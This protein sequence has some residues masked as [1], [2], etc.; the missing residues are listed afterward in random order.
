M[1]VLS[2][3]WE[4][5][6]LGKAVFLLRWGPCWPHELFFLGIYCWS[7]SYVTSQDKKWYYAA[8]QY[9]IV[10]LISIFYFLLTIAISMPWWD[11]FSA[12][13][14]PYGMTHIIT[15][16]SYR[17]LLNTDTMSSSTSP[18]DVSYSSFS[19]GHV[20]YD[21][22]WTHDSSFIINSPGSS[23]SPWDVSYSTFSWGDVMCTMTFIGPM[24]HDVLSIYLVGIL[25]LQS[26][27]SS[28]WHWCHKSMVS[29]QKGLICHA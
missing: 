16:Q 20:R 21:I 15:W 2:L 26:I 12:I 6:Y 23:S 3:T 1:T 22:H 27:W 17:I 4:H 5:P 19:W 14:S 13:S 8:L 24:N 28:L 9:A 29:C 11:I 25:W 10:D 7:H 18:W